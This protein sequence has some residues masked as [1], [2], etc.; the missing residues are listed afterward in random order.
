[1]SAFLKKKYTWIAPRKE[2][3][4]K[5]HAG[6]G[7]WRLDWKGSCARRDEMENSGCMMHTSNVGEET[8]THGASPVF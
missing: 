2:K 7:N 6:G 5:S 4:E 1:M 8:S 3:E